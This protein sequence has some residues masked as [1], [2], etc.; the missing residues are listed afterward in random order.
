MR[1]ITALVTSNP[2]N[3]GPVR[4]YGPRHKRFS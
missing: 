4:R 2:A 3:F 1:W